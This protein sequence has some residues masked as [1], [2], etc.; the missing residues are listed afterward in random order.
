MWG[1]A[2]AGCWPAGRFCVGWRVPAAYPLRMQK[3]HRKAPSPFCASFL[4]VLNST[5]SWW[6]HSSQWSH[7][8]HGSSTLT[9]FFALVAAERGMREPPT[10]T[11]CGSAL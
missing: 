7:C 9:S 5:Q 4:R 10:S 2:D 6:N 8:T 3:G 11:L 1:S